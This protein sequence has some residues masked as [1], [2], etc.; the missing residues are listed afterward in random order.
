MTA[1]EV[2]GSKSLNSIATLS[3][4]T[5]LSEY[6]SNP[7]FR[8]I[9]DGDLN[10][11]KTFIYKHNLHDGLIERNFFFIKS[12]KDNFAHNLRNYIN[13]Y[14]VIINLI[15][16]GFKDNNLSPILNKSFLQDVLYQREIIFNKGSEVT[17]R[18]TL[19]PLI[20][21]FLGL[22]DKSNEVVSNRCHGKSDLTEAS[23]RCRGENLVISL[24]RRCQFYG[25]I[26]V[27]VFIP[28]DNFTLLGYHNVKL[29]SLS[30]GLS[31]FKLS[32]ILLKASPSV[33]QYGFEIEDFTSRYSCFDK[34]SRCKVWYVRWEK[35]LS[36]HRQVYNFLLAT[37]QENNHVKTLNLLEKFNPDNPIVEKI[38]Y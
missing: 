28:G 27:K 8:T 26:K 4:E 33:Y 6:I 36:H 16:S 15:I 34:I 35:D 10:K 1:Y 19:K 9:F 30:L 23:N 21:E 29:V 3:L 7:S 31:Y 5:I 25:G 18:I 22:T 14:D 11:L 32:R 13:G 17:T 20:L 24:A 12:D 37:Y 38:T 2:L